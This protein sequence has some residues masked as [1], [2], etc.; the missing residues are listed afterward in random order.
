MKQRENVNQNP[1]FDGIGRVLC[2]SSMD[3]KEQAFV[4]KALVHEIQ[5]RL[6]NI[7]VEAPVE[8][9][10]MTIEDIRKAML[11]QLLVEVARIIND[12]YKTCFRK[13]DGQLHL[14]LTLFLNR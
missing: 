8:M 3:A 5:K 7:H 6:L 13:V 4:K 1:K 9:S 10:D 14:T 11:E 12:N 2:E